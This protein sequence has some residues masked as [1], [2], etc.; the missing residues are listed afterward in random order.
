MKNELKQVK[1]FIKELNVFDM[2]N[3]DINGIG[4]ID[5]KEYEFHFDVCCVSGEVDVDIHKSWI[6]DNEKA[7]DGDRSRCFKDIYLAIQ[8][9]NKLFDSNLG[10]LGKSEKEIK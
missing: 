9:L 6:E 3:K 7:F 8:Y 5:G 2:T 1:S 4:V 10:Y